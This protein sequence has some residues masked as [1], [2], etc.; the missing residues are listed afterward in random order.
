MRKI[1]LF[2]GLIFITAACTK[3]DDIS[4][5]DVR[6]GNFTLHSTSKF[7]LTL[8]IKVN[9]PTKR[10]IT[11]TDGTLEVFQQNRNLGTLS[12][13]APTVIAPKS[14]DYNQLVLNG[15]IKDIMALFGIRF[16]ADM[17]EMFDM[18]DVEGFL[19]VKAGVAGKK[20]KIDRTNFKNLLQGLL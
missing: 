15:T 19:K 3:Y 1:A 20:L 2:L 7:T 6:P 18:F 17:S 5:E 8:D 13:G 14:N 9:N 10:K 16:S 12:V 4:I 11:I